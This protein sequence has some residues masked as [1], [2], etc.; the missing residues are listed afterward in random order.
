MSASA[1]HATLAED[2]SEIKTYLQTT[3]TLCEATIKDFLAKYDVLGQAA[4]IRPASTLFQDADLLEALL[5]NWE[6]L[7]DPTI[8]VKFI[9]TFCL[10]RT[11][12]SSPQLLTG[13][14][15]RSA[16]TVLLPLRD[17]NSTSAASEESECSEEFAS[18][19]VPSE[20]LGCPP[21]AP[22]VRGD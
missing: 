5:D 10:I 22:G 7:L 3:D 1:S 11:S 15:Q 6:G 16:R 8:F 20:S 21:Q 19:P 4:L 12:P 17:W 13:T 9:Y 2:L 18:I 14:P